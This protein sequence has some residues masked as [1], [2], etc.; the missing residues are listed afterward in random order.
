MRWFHKTSQILLTHDHNLDRN[1]LTGPIPDSFECFKKPDIGIVLSHNQLFGSIPASLAHIKPERIDLSR[2]KLEGDASM[3]LGLT[4]RRK[5]LTFRGTCWHF[6]LS[7]VEFST[8]LMSIDLNHNHIYGSIPV[9]LTVNYLQGFNVSYNRLCGEIPQG[10]RLQKFD[11]DSYFH[12]KC[13][14]GSSLPICK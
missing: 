13:L 11:V 9:G 3:L 8:S 12:N 2:N 7:K 6:D 4:K 14:C 5:L 1:K 10:G